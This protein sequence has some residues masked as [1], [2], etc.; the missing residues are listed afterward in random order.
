MS[1]K[2]S[3]TTPASAINRVLR[4][5]ANRA[6][7]AKRAT[8]R[9]KPPAPP[10]VMYST[11]WTSNQLTAFA[12]EF[13]PERLADMATMVKSK[14]VQMCDVVL[15]MSPEK[16]VGFQSQRALDEAV[17]QMAIAQSEL[18]ER[19]FS[20]SQRRDPDSYP[21]I[22]EQVPLTAQP[23]GPGQVLSSDTIPPP[24]PPVITNTTAAAH[25]ATTNTAT[26]E[27]I[28]FSV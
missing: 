5:Q 20:R 13:I 9:A 2:S 24:Q 28:F 17:A 23:E 8:D 15:R 19:L 27:L 3:Q 11:K 18:I 1:K 21:E 26:L 10:L 25:P 22:T 12:R 14:K 4:T 7:F 16:F 6:T